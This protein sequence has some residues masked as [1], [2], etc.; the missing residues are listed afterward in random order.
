LVFRRLQQ[1]LRPLKIK[2]QK[3]NILQTP[4]HPLALPFLALHYNQHLEVTWSQSTAP[5][6]F[7]VWTA[8]STTAWSLIPIS[9]Q[10][11]W[12]PGSSPQP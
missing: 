4:P 2:C 7:S 12:S 1:Q 10:T 6:I 9:G 3:Q 5:F 11:L 8:S